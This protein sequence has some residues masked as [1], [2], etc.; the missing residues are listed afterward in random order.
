VW[1][2]EASIW[3]SQSRQTL[4]L[5]S[6]NPRKFSVARFLLLLG[7]T[8]WELDGGSHRNSEAVR[9]VEKHAR[10]W[11]IEGVR[12]WY[13][14]SPLCA[15]LRLRLE[16]REKMSRACHGPGGSLKTKPKPT[17]P[18]VEARPKAILC[19]RARCLFGTSPTSWVSP[20]L[21][22]PIPYRHAWL[23]TDRLS[24]TQNPTTPSFNRSV[25]AETSD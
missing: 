6:A 20:S 17:N 18:A 11:K 13:S 19:R 21:L 25:A 23:E 10:S 12:R 8:H 16:R 1:R 5:S 9:E 4:S 15:D 3:N 7:I 22:F 2:G 14:N 24:L